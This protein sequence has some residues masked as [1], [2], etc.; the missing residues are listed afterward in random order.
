MDAQSISEV[1]DDGILVAVRIRPLS[2]QEL[3]NGVQNCCQ[4]V[5]KQTVAIRKSGDA[6]GYL[7]SQMAST[8]EY[9]FDAVFGEN[10]TQEEVYMHTA[11]KYI[12]NLIDGK[13]VTVFAYGATG[14]GKTHTMLGNT[15]VDAAAAGTSAGIIPNA[16][17]DVFKLIDASSS[18]KPDEKWSI[19]LT[20]IEVYNE[21]V[22][23]LLEDSGKTLSIREDQERGVVIVAG[24]TEQSVASFEEVKHFMQV[25][26]RNRKTE[27]TMANEV[28]SRSHAVLQLTVR[29][30]ILRRE[31]NRESVI[32]SKLS[33]IDLAGSERAS[34]TNNRGARLQEGANINKSLLALAN[35]INAL[36]ENANGGKKLNVKFRDSKLTHLLKSS[37]E[38]N[39]NLIMIANINPSDT[40]QEDS[41]NTLKYAN[42]AKNIK[43]CPGIKE[44]AK[45]SSWVEREVRLIAENSGLQ[46]R[47]LELQ[48]VVAELQACKDLI[49]EKC[50]EDSCGLDGMRVCS[51]CSIGCLSMT[52]DLFSDIFYLPRGVIVQISS[53]SFTRR[54][55][56]STP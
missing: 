45:E 17:M 35:C 52:D 24:A 42:R 39:C 31:T 46:Q 4:V 38:G 12:P 40:T 32:E 47:V 8:N 43:V 22:Y 11:K 1:E 7:K 26:N 54:T 6:N 37:L 48:Q 20:Y 56:P 15:R 3:S 2:K 23:D 19:A 33:L 28:S 34:V 16:V 21:Q 29:R 36:S 51:L 49:L 44:S 18:L 9:A 55:M 50:C 53:R 30:T 25:G 41:Q 27:A 14:A 10:S 5:G 13:N